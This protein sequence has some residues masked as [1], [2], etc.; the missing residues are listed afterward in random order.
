MKRGIATITV[1]V[2][3]DNN[4]ELYDEANKMCKQLNDQ[5]DCRA[6]VEKLH[7]AP[8]GKMW[9]DIKEININRLKRD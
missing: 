9:D 3:G 1:Y 6:G 4:Q 2:Y 8:H 7:D 5:H